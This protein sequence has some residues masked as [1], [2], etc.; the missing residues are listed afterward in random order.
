MLGTIADHFGV[1][2]ESLAGANN[3]GDATAIQAGQVLV[4]PGLS[5][6]PHTPAPTTTSIDNLLGM[7][8]SMPIAGACLTPDDDQMPNAPREYRAGVH[9]GVD[10]FTSYACVDVPKGTPVLAAAGGTIIRADH[11]YRPLSEQQILDLEQKSAAQGYTDEG[12]LDKFRGRQVWIDHGN[13]IVTRYCH[14]SSIPAGIQVGVHVAQGEVIGATGDSGT[15]GSATN[16]DFEIHLHFEIRVGD[17][18]L[19]KG[20]DKAQT[21][22]IYEAVFGITPTTGP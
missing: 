13:G 11:D 18:Y 22:A 16:P 19:G 12:S 17:T 10:F 5:A 2:I 1:S 6:A 14:L 4:I 7:H 20:L 9:E 15:P 21:R 3:I 8:M